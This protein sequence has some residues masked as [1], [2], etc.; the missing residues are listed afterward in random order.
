MSD[1]KYLQEF[2]DLVP[3]SRKFSLREDKEVE[4]A[5]CLDN[6]SVSGCIIEAGVWKGQSINF[7][8]RHERVIDKSVYGFDSNLGLP[9]DWNM[10][11]CIIPASFNFTGATYDSNVVMYDG[12]FEDTLPIFKEDVP[13][14]ISFLNI[15]SDVYSS[16]VDVLENLNDRIVP[17]T[18]IRFDE[19]CCWRT[20]TGIDHYIEFYNGRDVPRYTTWREGEFKALIEWTE[21]Y[22]RTVRPYTRTGSVSGTVYVEE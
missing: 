14:N 2:L 6:M 8:A 9:H 1:I 17:G 10:G 18:I 4:I 3:I 7:I 22:N 21:K 15:D 12:W 19:L 16:C 5:H 13:E 11:S 20:E